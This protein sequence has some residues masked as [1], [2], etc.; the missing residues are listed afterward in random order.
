M[1]F[2][3]ATTENIGQY[4][5]EEQRRQA[6]CIAG[7]MPPSLRTPVL[8]LPGWAKFD[9]IKTELYD[10]A[11]PRGRLFGRIYRESGEL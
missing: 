6:G 1:R 8:R 10:T 3:S 2:D 11:T 5:R 9:A 4:L 7:R